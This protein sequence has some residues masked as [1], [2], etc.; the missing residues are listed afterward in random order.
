MYPKIVFKKIPQGEGD[1]AGSV[2]RN[3]GV[4]SNGK[5]ENRDQWVKLFR[6]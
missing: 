5:K 6:E 4:G 3:F 2:V 1:D